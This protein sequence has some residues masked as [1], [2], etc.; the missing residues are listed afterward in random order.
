MQSANGMCK[1]KLIVI[2]GPTASG[3]SSVAVELAKLINAN[4]ISADSMQVYRGMDIG[5]AKITK[6]EMKGVR[7]YLLDEF[8]PDEAFNVA[9][10]QKLA[11]QYIEE[12]HSHGNVPILAGGTGF[13]IQSVAFDSEFEEMEIDRTLRRE[14]EKEYDELGAA[15]FHEMLKKVDAGAAK[16]IHPNNKKRMVRALEYFRLT[17][18]RISEHNAKQRA[19]RSPYELYYF[20][21]NM[22]REI[23]Y[24]RIDERVDKLVEAGLVEEVNSLLMQGYS[25]NLV[26][27]QGLGYKEIAAYLEGEMS[28]EEAIYI[29]KRD[30]RHFAKRQW[31]WFKREPAC[32]WVDISPKDSAQDVAKR[33]LDVIKK[34]SSRIQE[35]KTHEDGV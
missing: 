5:T 35:M 18:E 2:A 22:D 34:D 30:T 7:H 32:R 27:M 33:I 21:L 6:E 23:L 12:I 14:L 25:R 19:K 3:K 13:Y 20:V 9:I 29:I 8:A 11:K 16:S 4:I 26:S 1:K 10:F 15:S 17:G 24:R 31:T 28:L